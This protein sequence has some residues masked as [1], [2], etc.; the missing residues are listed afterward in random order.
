MLTTPA[1]GREGQEDEACKASLRVSRT[2][3][4]TWY[5]ISKNRKTNLAISKLRIKESQSLVV[6]DYNLTLGRVDAGDCKSEATLDYMVASYLKIRTKNNKEG[7]NPRAFLYAST[8][9]DHKFEGSLGYIVRAFLR[10]KTTLPR[11]R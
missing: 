6:N 1:L 2:A 9:Q 5:P 7:R 4:A 3:W 10:N 8:C 11:P